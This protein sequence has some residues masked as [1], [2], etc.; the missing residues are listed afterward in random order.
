MSPVGHRKS[1]LLLWCVR[2]SKSVAWWCLAWVTLL[3]MMRAAATGGCSSAKWRRLINRWG[4]GQ[5]IARDD[6]LITRE[7]CLDSRFEHRASAKAHLYP[8]I[9]SDA[10]SACACVRVPRECMLAE[11]CKECDKVRV[12]RKRLPWGNNTSSEY[13]RVTR[14]VIEIGKGIS[15]KGND[16]ALQFLY[17]SLEAHL[18][19]SHTHEPAQASLFFSH[20]PNS[21]DIY[22]CVDCDQH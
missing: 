17:F 5:D 3:E 8:S 16:L 1:P 12:K 22:I 4:L 15:W 18:F 20:P 13:V 19:K 6:N 21:N 14:R 11:G 9:T 7:T 2:G 10:S